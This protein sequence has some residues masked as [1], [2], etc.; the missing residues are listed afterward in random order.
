MKSP[1]NI[2]DRIFLLIS[3]FLILILFLKGNFSPLASYFLTFTQNPILQPTFYLLVLLSISLMVVYPLKLLISRRPRYLEI[4]ILK[5][6]DDRSALLDFASWSRLI[7]GIELSLETI[8][9]EN[10]IKA[11]KE[12]LT[13][14]FKN[15]Y[16]LVAEEGFNLSHVVLMERNEDN[17][18]QHNKI[19]C[20]QYMFV[21]KKVNKEKNLDEDQRLISQ[22]LAKLE[23]SIGVTAPGIKADILEGDELLSAIELAFGAKSA[24][25]H[26]TPKGAV[27]PG[28]N[29]IWAIANGTPHSEVGHDLE[30][31]LALLSGK[32]VQSFSLPLEVIP[33][34]VSIFGST[35]SGK[36]TTA[37]VILKELYAHGIPFL[38]LD[39]HN[40]YA[41]LVNSLGGVVLNF[42]GDVHLDVLQ[43][44]S[45]DSANEHIDTITDVFSQIYNF[46]PP[47][48]YMFREAFTQAFLESRM[49]SKNITME[50]LV[51]KVESFPIRSF[52]ENET[53][54]A[55]LRRLKPLTTGEGKVIF[56]SG[57]PLK[58]DS[59]V[60]RPACMLLGNI[61][62]SDLRRLAAAMALTLVYEYRL[63]AGP[64]G[65]RHVTLIEE[66]Q[67][68][69]PFRNRFD[70]PSAI[71]KLFFEMRKYGEG[72]VLV[73][74]FPSQI[75]PDVVKSTGTR[76]VHRITELAEAPYVSDI[77]GIESKQCNQ[78][79]YLPVGKAYVFTEGLSDA[80]LVE[81][82]PPDQYNYIINDDVYQSLQLV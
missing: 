71:E 77:L 52:Y 50:S 69:L 3:S 31:G 60:I 75:F 7:G 36:T 70:P 79:K 5:L 57:S 1:I 37:K 40:E 65:L 28:I 15:I 78:L 49:L 54:Y 25:A 10:N 18:I 34:H 30:L 23:A 17:R 59:L 19:K 45:F 56:S 8:L 68:L 11:S 74:Q 16:A 46:S 58:V 43:P 53:K 14:R 24:N 26:A 20:F 73:A 81:V 80:I 63:V 32:P 39:V 47:Q 41:D 13:E 44:Y 21:Y 62:S 4:G 51:E 76:I 38:V 64:S 2:P 72:L 42:V 6:L 27:H 55:L 22:V 35:G 61:R 33:K 29:A 67:N 82:S 48:V 9:K 66:A 12:D